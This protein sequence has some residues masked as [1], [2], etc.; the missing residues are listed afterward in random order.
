[1]SASVPANHKYY[2][3]D[4]PLPLRESNAAACVHVTAGKTWRNRVTRCL[5]NF[6]RVDP[7]PVVR[8]ASRMTDNYVSSS[9]C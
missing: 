4:L 2:L 6:Q 8:A 9:V 5:G 1:M 3:E 7:S